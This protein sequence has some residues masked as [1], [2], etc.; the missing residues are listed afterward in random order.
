MYQ[1][2]KDGQKAVAI[3]SAKE[4]P[5]KI[6]ASRKKRKRRRSLVA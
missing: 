2:A 5:Y 1:S 4:M 3:D 6:T